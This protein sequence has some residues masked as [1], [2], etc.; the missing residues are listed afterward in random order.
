L[1]NDRRKTLILT[2]KP[3]VGRDFA[4]ALGIRGK[5]EGYLEDDRYIVAWA[6]GH[7]VELQEPDAYDPR[8]KTWRMETLPILPERFAYRPIAKTRKQLDIVGRLLARKDLGDVVIATDA[9]REGEVIGRTILLHSGRIGPDRL[10]RFWTSQAL[11]PAV[12]RAGMD[13]LAPAADYDRL[14]R[15][16]QARQ[17]AD[18]LVGMNLSR[19]ATLK[20]KDLF[21]VGR[22]QTAV[23]ALLVDRR[24]ERDNFKPEPYWLLKA[25]F[26]NE[27]GEWWGNWFRKAE[28]RFP[29][30]PAAR[31]VSAAVAGKTGRV[32][33][34][35]R[36]KKR[37]PPPLLFSLTD[38]QQEA[39]RRYGFSA[40]KTLSI[41]QALYEKRKCL[42]YPRTDARVLGAQSVGMVKGLLGDLSPIYPGIFAG[43]VDRL[44]SPANRRVFNDARLTDHHALIPLAKL[45]GGAG[46]DEEKIYDLVLRRFAA[47]FHPDCEYEAT[48][49]V[50]EVEKETFRTRGRIILKPGWQ[51]VYDAETS[52]KDEEDAA[53]LP[54]LEPDDPAAV[55]ETRVDRK[56]TQP[57][58]EYTEALL[59]REMTDPGRYVAEAVLK[60]IYRG[61]VGL[62]TQATRA[63]IIETLLKRKYIV[64]RKRHLVAVERGCRLIDTLR[65]LTATRPIASPEETAQWERQLEEIAQGTGEA[66]AFLSKIRGFVTDA[67]A[68]FQ[69]GAVPAGGRGARKLGRCP[70]CGGDVIE[71]KKGY[72]CAQWRRPPRGRGCRFVIWKVQAGAELSEASVV[73][74][75]ERGET[76]LLSGF[77]SQTGKT[78]SAR[79]RLTPSADGV[80]G[81]VF[82]ISRQ[83]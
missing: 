15:A 58:P 13:N 2:E 20:M 71:G 75:L 33:S 9:G 53:P 46:A 24:R 66:D 30:E 1:K 31:A 78:F 14:W 47:A 11:T 19:A 7:L 43:V 49:I 3:S 36:K 81:V 61:D 48:E 54:P 8:W 18:W 56:M 22:V 83:R 51:A 42:S 79:L 77:R 65:A 16:G 41:A 63:Q 28:T 73:Q 59:L 68:A 21:S 17:I 60:K 57:P 27:K 45:P 25:R 44:A 52:P 40:Q 23:L 38:L 50:T 5:G 26:T 82:D 10:R 32:R 4:K 64:R 70:A 80:P 12:V 74:L 69:S 76:D 62:G 55:A 35:S 72:G 6:L 67:V 39:N 37:Q 34:V 29:E